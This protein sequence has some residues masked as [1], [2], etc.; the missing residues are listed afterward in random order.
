MV[1]DQMPSIILP[2]NFLIDVSFISWDNQEVIAHPMPNTVFKSTEIPADYLHI[3]ISQLD[4]PFSVPLV[5][6]E[7]SCEFRFVKF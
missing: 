4:A 5:V 6:Y 3:L 7:K 2:A 1:S